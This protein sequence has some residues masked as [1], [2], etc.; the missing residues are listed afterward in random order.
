MAADQFHSL[1][2]FSAGIP[3]V[4]VIDANGN[5]VT[6]VLTSGN[7]TANTVFATFYRY[8]NG[9][10]ITVEAG[11]QNSQLQF[12]DNGS[13]GG[14]PNVTWDGSKLL[15]DVSSLGLLGGDNGYFLQTD[16]TGNL[17]WSPGG[18]GGA[19]GN[20]GGANT[21]VQFNKEGDFGGDAGF[22]YDDVTNTLGVEFITV[23]TVTGNLSGRATFSNVANT[24]SQS[25]QPN[26]TGVGTLTSLAVSGLANIDSVNSNS[27]TAN[28]I[29]TVDLVANGQ[30]NIDNLSATQANISNLF[31]SANASVQGVIFAPIVSVSNTVTSLNLLVTGNSNISGNLITTGNVNLAN[32]SVINLGSISNIKISGGINGFVLTTDG[33]GNL[34]WSAGGSGGNGIPGGTN[35]QVQ[36]NDDGTF[37]GDSFF[38]FN[39]QNKNVAISGNLIANSITIGSGVYQFSRSNV[40]FATTTSTSNTALIS[41]DASEVSSVDFTVIATDNIASYRQ[42]SKLS[43]VMYD[44]NVN[45]NEYSTLFVNDLVGDFSV[46]YQPGNA[47]VG[48]SVTL[49]VE[50]ESTNTTTYKIQ[51]TVYDE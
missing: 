21:Q 3:P 4:Q 34:T 36:F 39:K 28:S 29:Q 16:G 45:Y 2:G 49:F 8:A 38:T 32:S 47:I 33:A 41:L 44:A 20:P 13:F 51:I 43:A 24:V 42:V 31:V 37:A 25:F 15:L 22:V 35:T 26:I 6:N 46:G 27:L 5:V 23:D 11:G 40:F 1:G 10:S 30:S 18:G 14:T 19:N 50:P 12:N 7:V 17:T 48:P 9:Q